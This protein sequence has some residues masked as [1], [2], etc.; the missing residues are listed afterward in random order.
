MRLPDGRT[1]VMGGW[2]ARH[3]VASVVT[4][5]VGG[6]EWS[7]LAPMARACCAAV[8]AVLPDGKVLVAGGRT[9]LQPDSGLKTAELYDPATNAWTALPDMAHKRS[10]SGV[11]VLPSGRV[12]VVGG[13]GDDKQPR[14]DC[15]AFDP[16]KRT[17]E[18]L[19]ETAETI[20]NAAAAPVAGG[21][22][23]VG[24]EKVILFD[25]ESG[26]WLLLPHSMARPRVG[27]TQMVSLPASA[28][29]RGKPVTG[30]VRHNQCAE[31]RR[32]QM[33]LLLAHWPFERL[34]LDLQSSHL[35]HIAK[36]QRMSDLAC[37]NGAQDKDHILFVKN[38]PSAA[39]TGTNEDRREWRG[40]RPGDDAGVRHSG[41][42]GTTDGWT[43]YTATRG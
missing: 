31:K 43:D 28:L 30:E 29:L 20:G 2:V 3:M 7:A 8:A 14:Q 21:M 11:C 32:Q 18:P 1:P 15:E 38:S 23:V 40:R 36:H 34:K 12:A 16:V 6:S 35:N 10:Q 24:R 27:A 17:R 5:A 4:L 37:S 26:R 9:A 13:F 33:H 41:G 19:P 42:S 22:I 25:E 39:G